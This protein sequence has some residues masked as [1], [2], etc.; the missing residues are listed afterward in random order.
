MENVPGMLTSKIEAN[1]GVLK[2]VDVVKKRSETSDIIVRLNLF[3]QTTTA[4]LNPWRD[5]SWLEE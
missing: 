4:F 3:G 1:G 5:F 2:I